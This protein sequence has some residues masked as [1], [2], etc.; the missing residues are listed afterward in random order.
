MLISQDILISAPYYVAKSSTLNQTAP[1]PSLR[2][3]DPAIIVSLKRHASGSDKWPS[4]PFGSECRCVDFMCEEA[5]VKPLVFL[6]VLFLATVTVCSA[7]GYKLSGQTGGH[8]VVMSFPQTRPVEGENTV[9]IVISDTDSLPVK[10]ALV[11]VEYLMPSLPGKRP[12]MDY[13]TTAKPEGKVYKATLNLSMKG[14]WRAVV[15]I[16]KG[17]QNGTVTLPFE[18][19]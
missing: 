19:K 13:E 9:E 17:K 8:R 11:K 6:I 12:M 1:A 15:T 4:D 14:E 2:V 18:V 3:T 5:Y 7:E 10:N 16:A